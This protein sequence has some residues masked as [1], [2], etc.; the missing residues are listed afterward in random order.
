MRKVKTGIVGA[1]GQRCCFH[2]GCVF[3]ETDNV[4]I[5]AICDNRPERL[6]Y[7]KEMYSK[8]LGYEVET[9]LDYNEMY[10]KADLEAVYVSGPN[11]LHMEM[12][13]AAL[14]AGLHVLCEKPMEISLERADAIS[15]AAKRSGKLLGLGMQ[16]HYRR[17]YLKIGELVEQGLIGNVVQSWC[18]E[19]RHPYIAMKDWVW[20]SS[21]SGGAIH[22]K[23][24][25][26]YDVM[27]I[28]V[29]SKPTTVYASGNIM[30]HHTPHGIKSD[31][32]DNA[33]IINDYENGSRAMVSINFMGTNEQGHT[34]EFGVIGTDGAITFNDTDKEVLHV[35]L[36]NGDKYDLNIP[37]DVRGGIWQDFIDCV[38]DG[39]RQP[40]VTP[41]MGRNSLLVPM[42]AEL[43]IKEKR[44]VNVNELK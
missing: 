6:A 15:D 4:I 36:N 21:L 22:E 41:E 17:R 24:C 10:A 5:K 11:N 42:A 1:G 29:K 9:Y 35:S 32:V 39:K 12:S 28:W 23:N 34:R 16:M 18:S 30:K 33:F 20:D 8:Y 2:G 19:Y 26:H 13:V 43:S 7:A 40:L 37:G 38:L 14:T 3:A 44:I 25:H 27:D 31:I